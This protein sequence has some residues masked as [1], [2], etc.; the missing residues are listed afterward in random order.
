MVADGRLHL[1]AINMLARH[2]KPPMS[3]AGGASLLAA[4]A[5]KTRAELELMLAER[6]PQTDLMPLVSPSHAEPSSADGTQPALAR[7]EKLLEVPAT[8]ASAGNP[9]PSAKVSALSAD[10]IG[11]QFTMS[12]QGYDNLRRA[13]ELLSHQFGPGDIA[14]VI[15]WAL[16]MAIPQLEK[17]KFAT[18]DKP[19]ASRGRTSSNPRY[20]PAHVRRAVR[21]RDGD[22]CTYVSASGRRCTARTRLEF[23]H[24]QEVARGGQATV[25]NIRLRCREHNQFTAEQTLGRDFMQRKREAA[26][27]RARESAERVRAAEELALSYFGPR[28]RSRHVIEAIS[29]NAASHTPHAA[30][31]AGT[32]VVQPSG[33]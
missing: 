4:A 11:V 19:R 30:H 31:D 16:Q 25:D 15:E 29:A 20:I 3:L 9:V 6:F 13:Q 7:V 27:E 26:Q 21:E 28:A 18:T 8:P 1:T 17:R 12:R 23:D 33:T 5:H 2:L 32:A 24:I 22:Q 10:G 14:S